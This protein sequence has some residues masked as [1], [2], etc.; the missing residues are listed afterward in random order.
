MLK[1]YDTL[2]NQFKEVDVDE[3]LEKE[4]KRSY[5][6]EEISER[7][8]YAR[9]MQYEEYLAVNHSTD[10]ADLVIRQQEIS[11]LLECIAT[12]PERSQRLIYFKY[13]CGMTDI[14]IGK[15]LGISNSYAGRLGKQ[16][17]VRIR[18]EMLKRYS[19]FV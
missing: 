8:Y 16:I 15:R 13:Y 4:Y 2:S 7:R 18:E 14:E 19:Y 11:I 1:C 17:K 12:L 6:R 5:W 9:S 3:E 10:V